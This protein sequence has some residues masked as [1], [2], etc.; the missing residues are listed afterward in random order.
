MERTPLDP[1]EATQREE[2]GRT[3]DVLIVALFAF[4]VTQVAAGLAFGSPR[5]VI[6]GVLFAALTIWLAAFSRRAL[7][8]RPMASVV[9][10]MAAALI[11]LPVVVAFLQ[12]FVAGVAAVALLIPIAA[13]L[14]ILEGGILR[15]LMFLAWAG[16]IATLATGY[17]PDDPAVPVLAASLTRIWGLVLVSGVVLFLLYRSSERLKA[18]SR[19]FR[20]LFQ[21]SSDLAE[22]T[23]PA[24]LGEI[25]ARHL[26]EATGYDDCVIYALAPE[27]G[28]LAP[29]GSHPVGRALVTDPESLAERPMLGRVIHDRERIVLDSADEQADPTEQERLRAL[30]RDVMLLLPLVAH[31]G[32]VGVAELTATGHRPLDER[33][34]ALARTLAFEA[35]MAIENG[36]LYQE[37]RHRA[38]HDPLTGLANRSLFHDRV[39]HA[40]TRLARHKESTIAVLFIDLDDF[41]VVNDTLGHARGDRLLVLLGE[42]LRTV[43]RPTDT[44]ARLGGDEFALLLEEVASGDEALAVARRAIAAAALPLELAGQPVSISISIGVAHRSTAGAS[45]AELLG[46]ADAAMYEAKRTGKGRAVRFHPGLRGSAAAAG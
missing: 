32:P 9:G 42:R 11:V 29:F 37:L 23:E 14:P 19:E 7:V 1:D 46:E 35:A 6:V 8:H 26:A 38:L 33:R 12:P 13:A 34:L 4:G 25:V 28:R 39:E 2:V 44:V 16:M 40:L 5:S 20:R 24:V 45:V 30:G 31:G 10:P 41:K 43:V 17:I 3:I 36:R 22:T 15:R 27:T 18:S 21:L